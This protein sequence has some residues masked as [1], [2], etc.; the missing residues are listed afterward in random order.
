MH[1]GTAVGPY[2]IVRQLG[3]GGM[4]IV[5][6]AEDPR[7]HRKVALKTLRGGDSNTAEDRQRLLR[8]ARAAA[9]LNHPNIA[10]VHDVLDIDG[11]VIVVF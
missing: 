6:L 11:Q 8:E 2:Q 10:A 1:A 4:G 9:A 3:A 7:L 5:W